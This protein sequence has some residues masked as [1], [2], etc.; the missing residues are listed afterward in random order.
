MLFGKVIFDKVSDSRFQKSW[1]WRDYETFK[2]AGQE[3][4]QKCENIVGWPKQ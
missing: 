1:G 2:G 4:S 3:S